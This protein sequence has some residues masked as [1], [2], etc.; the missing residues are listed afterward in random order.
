MDQ[1]NYRLVGSFSR[2]ASTKFLKE[3]LHLRPGKVGEGL[4]VLASI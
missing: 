1:W 3:A 4:R 2:Q